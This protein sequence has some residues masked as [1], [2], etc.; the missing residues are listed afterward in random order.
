V[1]QGQGQGQSVVAGNCVAVA[2]RLRDDE[3]RT[4]AA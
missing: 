4:A 3:R 2:W 1:G